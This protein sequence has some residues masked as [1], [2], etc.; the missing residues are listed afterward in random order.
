MGSENDYSKV[1]FKKRMCEY[2]NS[3]QKSKKLKT[4]C[5]EVDLN[6][7]Q[8]Y[9]YEDYYQ[10]LFCRNKICKETNK[11]QSKENKTI[12]YLRAKK[13]TKP[14]KHWFLIKGE[15]N[16]RNVKHNETIMKNIID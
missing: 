7:K 2:N 5:Q 15:V 13:T 16:T 1:P 9:T 11:K 10:S 6:Q 3:E 12:N 14:I 4:E 8:V